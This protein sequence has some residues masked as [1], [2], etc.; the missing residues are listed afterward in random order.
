MERGILAGRH[1]KP[2]NLLQLLV[3]AP[4]F[5]EVSIRDAQ[6]SLFTRLTI[7]LPLNLI[8]T[9]VGAKI[10]SC[11]FP[12]F[13]TAILPPLTS[14]TRGRPSASSLYRSLASALVLLHAIALGQCS[15]MR[16]DWLC[17]FCIHLDRKIQC[18][19]SPPNLASRCSWFPNIYVQ[20]FSI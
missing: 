11:V 10:A 5:G 15:S 1:L 13:G 12:T 6:T 19:R 7:S 3:G 8:C 9:V 18:A 16:A 2:K 14:K 17:P 4:S 20:F